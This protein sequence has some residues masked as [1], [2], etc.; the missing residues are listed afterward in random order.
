MQ[1]ISLNGS[2]RQWKKLT[3]AIFVSWSF[4]ICLSL[5]K[6]ENRQ[7]YLTSDS[8]ILASELTTN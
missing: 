4:L 2:K 6:S 7:D 5:I 3:F 1:I 8:K